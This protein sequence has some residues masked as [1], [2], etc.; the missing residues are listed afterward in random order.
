MEC[1]Q[2]TNPLFSDRTFMYDLDK[3]PFAK[4]RSGSQAVKRGFVKLSLRNPIG[5][6]L[7]LFLDQSLGGM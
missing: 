5:A 4:P 1:L 6:A 7:R 2:E 3:F